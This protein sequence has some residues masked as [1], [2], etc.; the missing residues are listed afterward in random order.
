MNVVPVPACKP[1]LVHGV[2]GKGAECGLRGCTE[3]IPTISYA[4][5]N[6]ICFLCSPS[7]AATIALVLVTMLVLLQGPCYNRTAVTPPAA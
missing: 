5:Y 6:I 3:S 2:R 7:Q 1:V 4:S